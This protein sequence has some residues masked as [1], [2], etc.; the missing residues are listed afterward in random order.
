[1]SD[2]ILNNIKTR[3]VVRE[4]TDEGVERDQIETILDAG[5]WAP[6]GGNLRPIRYVVVEDPETRRLIRLVA[7]GMF[8]KAPV[9]VLICINWDI[10]DAAQG[11][12]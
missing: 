8:Q 2:E 6:T 5:R 7:P 12:A 10:V 11:A 9:L 3:R 4:L 1:M